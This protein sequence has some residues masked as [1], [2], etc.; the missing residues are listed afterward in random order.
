M[1][2]VATLMLSACS[3]DDNVAPGEWNA[4]DGYADIYF[5]VASETEEL[6][7]A[8]PTTHEV[9][10]ARRDTTNL[11]AL[12]VPI[13]IT[14]GSDSIFSITDAVFAEGEKETKVTISFPEAKLGVTYEVQVAVTD[15]KYA[16]YY[17][18]ANMYKYAVTRVKWVLLG[19]GDL[20]DGFW[21]EDH[22]P[23][24]VYMKDGDPNTFRIED[25][26]GAY[27]NFL[28]GNQS[29][30]VTFTILGKGQPLSDV[31][32]KSR[33]DDEEE[34]FS[35]GGY[36]FYTTMNTGY[37][38]P[39]YGADIEM[40]HPAS[41]YSVVTEDDFAYQYVDQWQED[42]VEIE[43]KKYVIPGYIK[44][45]P[46]YYMRGVGGWNNTEEDGICT[47]TFP[48]FEPIS[49]YNA[50]LEDD[51]DWETVYTGD[52]I[53]TVSGSAASATLYKGICTTTTDSCDVRF[54]KD[55]GTP[56]AIEA[57]YAEGYDI[58]FFLKNGRIS[59]PNDFK[60][61]FEYQPTGLV[62]NVGQKN[63]FAK[64]NGSSSSFSENEVV[65]NITFYTLDNRGNE[66]DMLGTSDEVLS[67]AWQEIGT[68]DYTYSC[69]F[70]EPQLDEGLTI[71]KR[72]DEDVYKISDWFYGVDFLFTWDTKTNQVTVP[73]QYTG[74]TDKTYGD[75]NISDIATYR[76]TDYDEY[77]CYFDPETNTFHVSV[78]YYVSAGVFGSGEETFVLNL[79]DAGVKANAVRN[80]FKA[81]LAKTAPSKNIVNAMPWIKYAKN[82]KKVQ[83]P[84]NRA[85]NFQKKVE[86]TTLFNVA[87]Q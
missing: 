67:N 61:E 79:N 64:I 51:F 15:P 70:E 82:A 27:A 40:F 42:S 12:T 10:V 52:F 46:Y 22:L 50:T 44:F 53:S 30:F 85:K 43:G 71:S 28:D 84:K 23:T 87:L 60:E 49:L 9:V 86:S 4:V 68:V 75:C 5:P 80:A 3:D 24:K 13:E 41:L 47:L 26:F 63:I 39:T 73:S 58:Y 54:E 11:S 20:Y 18:N 17:S 8:D 33:L 35:E 36:V 7:P 32:A 81:P 29:E 38:H 76:K 72:V 14:N 56:Y 1:A 37:F 25:P 45:A 59:I 62:T 6:D 55:Y 21:F 83:A 69:M 16:S 77:P 2:A 19:V 66:V 34:T 74:Y 57:P 31:V 65:L 78:V 48:D